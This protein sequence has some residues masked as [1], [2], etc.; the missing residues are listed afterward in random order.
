L[1]DTDR[2]GPQLWSGIVAALEMLV[3]GVRKKVAPLLRRPGDLAEA[4]RQLLVDLDERDRPAA[5]LVID[6]VH[7]AWCD[8]TPSRVV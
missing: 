6:V 8:T 5:L 4:V 1:D 3:P 7:L 2:D